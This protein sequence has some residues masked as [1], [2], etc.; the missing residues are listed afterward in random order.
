MLTDEKHARTLLA[1][2]QGWFG[3]PVLL[4]RQKVI[5]GHK[6]LAAWRGLAF[7][8][9]PPQ[10]EAESI[11]RAARYL[12]AA[13]HYDRAAEVLQGTLDHRTVSEV[14]LLP[15]HMCAPLVALLKRRGPWTIRERVQAH[16]PRRRTMQVVKRVRELYVRAVEDGLTVEPKHLKEA[17]GE[18]FEGPVS[19]G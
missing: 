16:G 18:W 2:Y 19:G 6:R 5:D 14:L 12:C 9:A 1:M 17:L 13:E 8:E 7:A 4:F 10:V 3:P 15:E 11:W